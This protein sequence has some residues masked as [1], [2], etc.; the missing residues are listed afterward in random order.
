MAS[1]DLKGDARMSAGAAR[2]QVYTDTETQTGG[3][4]KPESFGTMALLS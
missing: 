2:R 3:E 1:P 4:K